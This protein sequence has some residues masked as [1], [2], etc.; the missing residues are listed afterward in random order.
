MISVNTAIEVA[1]HGQVPRVQMATDVRM[2]LEHIV[3]EYDMANLRGKS[4]RERA[5]ALIRIART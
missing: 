3:T 5:L 1:L 2:D 4:T